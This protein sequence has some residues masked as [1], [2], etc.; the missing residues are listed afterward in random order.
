MDLTAEGQKFVLVFFRV[1]SILWFLPLFSTRSVSVSFKASLSLAIAFLIYGAAGPQQ[2]IVGDPY[3]MALFMVKE[4][5]MGLAIGFFMRTLM[6]TVNAAG[7]IISLQCGFSFAR[8]M[9][10]INMIQ[11]T[12]LEQFKGMLA[13]VTFFAVDGHHILIAGMVRSF[14]EVPVGSMSVQMPLVHYLIDLTGRMISTGFKIG[15]PVIITLLF[16]EI[17]LGMLSRMIPQ[18]NIFVEGLPLKI[19]ITITMLSLSLGVIVQ[20]IVGLF[21]SVDGE[22]LKIMKLMG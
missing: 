14:K 1:V 10:P 17:A 4:V 3:A 22:L 2:T 12:V 19:L 8:F 9:D 21:K 13:A 16:V 5:L 15:A 11:V 20:T 6:L 18:V 7:E